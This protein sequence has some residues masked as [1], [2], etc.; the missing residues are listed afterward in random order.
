MDELG[1]K[2]EIINIFEIFSCFDVILCTH[3]K[4]II[5]FKKHTKRLYIYI[6]EQLIIDFEKHTKRF[7]S[8]LLFYMIYIGHMQFILY[9]LFV[10]INYCIH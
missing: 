9:Y 4:L 7:S 3:E 5:D 10:G 2:E 1:E 8:K 6:Y